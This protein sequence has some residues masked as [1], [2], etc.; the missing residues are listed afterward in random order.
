LISV[1]IQ[2]VPGA[3]VRIIHARGAAFLSAV[4]QPFGSGSMINS[5]A[6]FRR[7]RFHYDR[8]HA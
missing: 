2:G 6:L 3:S 7:E 4:A 8:S 1:N 5:S